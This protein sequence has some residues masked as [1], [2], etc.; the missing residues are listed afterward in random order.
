MAV[1]YVA[2]PDIIYPIEGIKLSATA[3]GVRYKD[4][5]DLVLIEIADTVTVLRDGRTICTLDAKNGQVTEGILIKHMVGREINNVY[6]PRPRSKHGEVIFQVQNLNAYNPKI[7]RTILKDINFNV[8]KGEIVGF[9]GL[10]G[11][12]RTELALSLFGNP[13]GFEV[14]GEVIVEGKKRDFTFFLY[15][16][17]LIGSKNEN[18]KKN[19][20]LFELIWRTIFEEI[21]EIIKNISENKN[22]DKC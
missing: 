10:M 22:F 1:G 12:G 2:V 21:L 4:R 6:P 14:S 9:A 13:T 16:I 7:G 11:S 19:R 8:K 20:K 5:D 18:Y 3:A 17:F 15:K